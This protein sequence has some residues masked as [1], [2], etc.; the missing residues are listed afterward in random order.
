MTKQ[1]SSSTQRLEAKQTVNDA[2]GELDAQLTKARAFLD[3]LGG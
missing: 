1:T 3:G 2:S